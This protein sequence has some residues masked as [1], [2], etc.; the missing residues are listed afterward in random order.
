MDL[1]FFTLSISLFDSLSTTLQI[2]LFVLLLTTEKPFRNAVVYLVGLTGSYFLCGLG[3]YFVLDQLRGLLKTLMPPQDIPNPLYYQ[4]ELLMG[5][6]LIVGGVGYFYWKKGKG[7]SAKENWFI[8]KLR[9]MNSWVALGLGVFMSVTSFPVSLPYLAALGKYASLQMN[10]PTVTGFIFLYNFGYALPMLLIF[11]I[12]LIAQRGTD[13]LHDALHE[14][15]R[16]LNLHLT[17]WTLVAF[18]FFTIVDAVCYFVFGQAL[19]KDRFF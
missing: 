7:W 18:G 5:I 1:F 8:S 10:L 12:Y 9:D 4:T 2:I 3:G 19:M 15:A 13:D 17:T 14:K 6:I 11:W 16:M